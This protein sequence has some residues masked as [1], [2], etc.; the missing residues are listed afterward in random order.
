MSEA[1]RQAVELAQ[2][3]FRRIAQQAGMRWDG[4]ND[5]EIDLMVGCII[6]AAEAGLRAQLDDA[7]ERVR[8]QE[9]GHQADMQR[10]NRELRESTRRDREPVCGPPDDEEDR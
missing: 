2:F 8:Q 7:L 9:A 4:D 6:D 1:Q 5:T 10:E 3:Y